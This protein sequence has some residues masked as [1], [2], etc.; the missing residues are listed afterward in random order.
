MPERA[1]SAG[2]GFHAAYLRTADGELRE[3][4]PGFLRELADALHVYSRTPC[5]RL[6]ANAAF[7]RF[8]ILHE[9]V[10]VAFSTQDDV[11]MPQT[12]GL[13]LAVVTVHGEVLGHV[14]I[15]ADGGNVVP[16]QCHLS[17]SAAGDRVL[18]FEP[19][20]GMRLYELPP[21]A[22]GQMTMRVLPVGEVAGGEAVLTPD[23]QQVFF[24]RMEQAGT[25]EVLRHMVQNGQT[26]QIGVSCLCHEIGTPQM[27]VSHDGTS[28][29]LRRDAN[30]LTLVRLRDGD[31]TEL[32]FDKKQGIR[33][34]VMDCDGRFFAYQAGRAGEE[35]VTRH[36][37]A[38]ARDCLV[39]QEGI[40]QT[41]PA[42]SGDGTK[43]AFVGTSA[44]MRQIYV[45]SAMDN[46]VCLNWVGGWQ[47]L[48][49]PF[50][51]DDYSFGMLLSQ[52]EAWCYADG[53][54]E[55]CMEAPQS[56]VGF[57]YR[58]ASAGKAVVSGN[59]E[60]AAAL[61]QGFNLIAPAAYP[62]VHQEN[63]LF[64][65]LRERA[66]VRGKAMG[67]HEAAWHYVAAE[68]KP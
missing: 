48:A 21:E 11:V 9:Y 62:S 56:G 63:C 24:F 8:A 55:R 36:D 68:A 58:A 34:P 32:L 66:W 26:E 28:I 29:V 49:F 4:F 45:A 3:L 53:R 7:T 19:S 37:T 31:R 39:E 42:L 35:K 14:K 67:L 41:L 61:R 10:A 22:G 46:A 43:L 23:G 20:C 2:N 59:D 44:G 13:Q 50:H 15:E 1:D 65:D 54:F 33:R 51:L 6:A 17:I 30:S 60:P 18:L 12:V 40:V 57:W 47:P 64:Y 16:A 5:V 25:A 27:A 38:R 52:G